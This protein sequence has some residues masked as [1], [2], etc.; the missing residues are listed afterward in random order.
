MYVFNFS[1]FMLQ[2]C[3]AKVP[4]DKVPWNVPFPEYTAVSYTV[5]YVLA[6]PVWADLDSK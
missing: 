6:G 1:I 4:D 2:V 3:R 5:D